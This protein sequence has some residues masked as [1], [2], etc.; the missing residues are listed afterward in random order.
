MKKLFAGVATFLLFSLPIVAKAEGQG[1]HVHGVATLTLALENDSLEI[2]FESPAANLLGFEY[3]AKSVDEKKKVMKAEAIL[4]SVKQLFM[5]EGAA[6]DPEVT[7][8]DVS[9]VMAKKRDKHD[10][11]DHE[12]HGHENHHHGGHDEHHH[13]EHGHGESHSE[14]VANY[15]LKC[16]NTKK[17]KSVST[18][19]LDQFPGI[20]EI[21]TMWV[22]ESSQGAGRLKAKKNSI[23]LR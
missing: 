5:F 22:T 4:V 6:C 2:H 9:G 8:V 16:T 19:L 14:I 18:T 7:T 3:K 23:I 15:Q 12:K 13:D 11:H 10:E 20:E 21:Q 17:L 1:A